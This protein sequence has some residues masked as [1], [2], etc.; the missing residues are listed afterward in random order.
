MAAIK[1]RVTSAVKDSKIT[2]ALEKSLGFK[3]N[4]V[5]LQKNKLAFYLEC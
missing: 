1:I 5:Q 2:T 3:P 4:T